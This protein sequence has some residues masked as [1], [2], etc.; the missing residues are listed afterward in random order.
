MLVNGGAKTGNNLYEK[1]HFVCKV[2]HMTE[3]RK[4]TCETGFNSI[5]L[6]SYLLSKLYAMKDI[7]INHKFQITRTKKNL[8]FQIPKRNH[9]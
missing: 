1:L 7:G 4:N 3:D 6:L 8:K 5:E 9:K 2:D